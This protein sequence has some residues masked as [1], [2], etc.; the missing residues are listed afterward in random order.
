MNPHHRWDFSKSKLDHLSSTLFKSYLKVSLS[1]TA[2]SFLLPHTYVPI[3]SYFF[4]YPCPSNSWGNTHLSF[5][6]PSPCCDFII[7]GL[8]LHMLLSWVWPYSI[9]LLPSQGHNTSPMWH[10]LTTNSVST[11]ETFISKGPKMNKGSDKH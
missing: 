6:L 4:M 9:W 7:N 5:F 1:S 11:G 8:I 2:F 10:T 3:R